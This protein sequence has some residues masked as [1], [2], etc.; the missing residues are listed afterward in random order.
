[1]KS[2]STDDSGDVIVGTTIALIDDENE[3]LRQKVQRVLGTNLGEWSFDE[4]EGIDFYAVLTKKPDED[5][6]RATIEAAL[7]HIDDTLY[8]T[9]FELEMHEGRR[10]TITI[11]AINADGVTVGGDYTYGDN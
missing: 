3:I 6:I 8:L 10:A 11:Q 7:Q 5:E 2:F 1:M 9:A 4:A